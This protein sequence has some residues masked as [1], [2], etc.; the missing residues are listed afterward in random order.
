M[1]LLYQLG[2]VTFV[3]VALPVALAAWYLVASVASFVLYARDKTA[4]KLRA[5]RTSEATLHLIDAIGGWPGG[6]IAQRLLRHKTAKTSFQA[7][8]FLT[9]AVNLILLWLLSV[10]TG[11]AA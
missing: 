7:V 6:L 11:T 10:P 3:V 1:P 4:A 2:P 9:I 8:F 5:P